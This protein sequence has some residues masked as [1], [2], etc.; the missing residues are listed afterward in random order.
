ME[1]RMKMGGNEIMKTYTYSFGEAIL[2]SA[3]RCKGTGEERE[4]DCKS[5]QGDWA[6]LMFFKKT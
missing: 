1:E 2:Q 4:S 5:E 6:L 3:E